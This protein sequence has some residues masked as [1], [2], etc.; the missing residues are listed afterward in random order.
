MGLGIGIGCEDF[1]VSAEHAANKNGMAKAINRTGFLL[2]SIHVSSRQ[3]FP[4][5]YTGARRRGDN[6]VAMK[7]T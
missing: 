7:I 2:I 3:S 5:D 6:P 1:G 4:H